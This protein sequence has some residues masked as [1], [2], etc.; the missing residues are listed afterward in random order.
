[1]KKLKSK[2]ILLGIACV[3]I[4]LSLSSCGTVAATTT[5]EGT[6][7]NV[8]DAIVESD[9]E[10]YTYA[11]FPKNKVKDYINSSCMSEEVYWEKQYEC[12]LRNYA[13]Q[14]HDVVIKSKGEVNE[15]EI[16]YMENKLLESMNMDVDIEEAYEW[17]EIEYTN[18]NGESCWGIIDKMYRVGDYWYMYP[19]VM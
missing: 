7:T 4:L 6:I 1:M 18:E 2:R 16:Q 14:H 19:S 11:M 12:M 5:M 9:V 15:S 10:K 3:L 13:E 8:Y 17:I